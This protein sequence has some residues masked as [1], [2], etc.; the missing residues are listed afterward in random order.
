MSVK[1]FFEFVNTKYIIL[2]FIMIVTL[3]GCSS[4]GTFVYEK[5]P[6]HAE[7]Y[8]FKEYFDV[9]RCDIKKN[10]ILNEKISKVLN[11]N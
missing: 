5:I 7:C 9:D 8:R 2:N 1:S 10:I 4:I 3:K 6:E 11:K